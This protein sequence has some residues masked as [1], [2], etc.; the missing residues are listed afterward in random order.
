M[1]SRNVL[2]LVGC[3]VA[4]LAI[5]YAQ[6]PFRQ[7]PGREYERLPAPARLAG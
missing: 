5:L 2:R 7:Y 3:G 1:I 4:F 6:K